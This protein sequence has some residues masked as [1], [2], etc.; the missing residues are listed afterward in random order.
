M[1]YNSLTERILRLC[2]KLDSLFLLDTTRKIILK[3]LNELIRQRNK[4]AE[5]LIKNEK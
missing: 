5:T 4:L 1:D 3:E 2:Y